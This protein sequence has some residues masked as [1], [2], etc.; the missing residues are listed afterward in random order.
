M[1][2]TNLTDLSKVIKIN[3]A[4]NA[5]SKISLAIG[6]SA[7]GE[8]TAQ[9]DV[10]LNIRNPPNATY[11]AVMQNTTSSFN[12]PEGAIYLLPNNAAIAYSE[13]IR[14][15]KTKTK[16]PQISEWPVVTTYR[17]NKFLIGWQPYRMVEMIICVNEMG[18]S[19]ISH[20]YHDVYYEERN[21]SEWTHAVDKWLDLGI[22]Q[23][24]AHLTGTICITRL[25]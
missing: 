10:Y 21:S 2:F 7:I 16:D 20:S 3:T 19:V 4:E 23:S 25:I 11:R 18:N 24:T 1:P 5:D 14:G 12:I 6:Q 22:I 9:Q 17:S 15:V 8:F 13:A